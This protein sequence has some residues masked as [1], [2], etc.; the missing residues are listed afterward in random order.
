MLPGLEEWWL[1][2]T[3]DVVQNVYKQILEVILYWLVTSS[4]G[5]F[6]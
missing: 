6:I 2:Q 1:Q 3:E 4:S 5:Y